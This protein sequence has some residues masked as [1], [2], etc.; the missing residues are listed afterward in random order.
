MTTQKMALP[1]LDE[2]HHQ[3][4]P[5][6]PG[7]LETVDDGGCSGAAES[8]LAQISG[9]ATRLLLALTRAV[10]LAPRPTDARWLRHS[11]TRWRRTGGSAAWL[12]AAGESMGVVA[13]CE[14][15]V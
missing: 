1:A 7:S 2:G 15:I 11:P 14:L 8:I 12:V 5:F 9:S 10:E 13:L 3:E 6:G 4:K